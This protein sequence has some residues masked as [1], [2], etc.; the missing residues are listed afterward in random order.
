VHRFTGR[1]GCRNAW[2]ITGGE[3]V[4]ENTSNRRVLVVH[5]DGSEEVVEIK[6][7]L[8]VKA[9]DITE[10]RRRLLAQGVKDIARI[11]LSG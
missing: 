8:G 3:G 5:S 7:D 11:E 10:M 4:Y 1:F 6:D 9:D 2:H